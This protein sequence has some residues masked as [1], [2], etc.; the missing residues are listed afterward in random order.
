MKTS[1]IILMGVCGSGKSTIASQLAVEL[2]CRYIDADDFH[3]SQNLVKLKNNQPLTDED[4]FPWLTQLSQILGD[5][6]RYNQPIVLACSALKHQYRLILTQELQP[7]SFCFFLLHA[8]TE[9]LLQRLNQ[10]TH[11]FVTAGLLNSQLATLEITPDL[12]KIDIT[13]TPE[14]IISQILSTLTTN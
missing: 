10:R 14:K 6:Q 4:R 5:A 3:P 11:H 12:K 13:S 1:I 8:S 9:I 2:N 7:Q